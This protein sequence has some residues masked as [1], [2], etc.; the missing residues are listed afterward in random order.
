MFKNIER[1]LT[2]NSACS[3][4]LPLRLGGERAQICGNDGV[5]KYEEKKEKEGRTREGK[6]QASVRAPESLSLSLPD[7]CV[8]QCESTMTDHKSA[9]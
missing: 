6:A 2:Y 8:S 1:S 4:M 9:S 3:S 7:P 5:N